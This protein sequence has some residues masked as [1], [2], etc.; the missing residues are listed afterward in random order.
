MASGNKEIFE[1]MNAVTRTVSFKKEGR[2][3]QIRYYC[4]NKEISNELYDK[5]GVLLHRA[6]I[7]PDGV[8]REYYETGA[9]KRAIAFQDGRAHGK[10]IDYYPSGDI[11]EENTFGQGLLQGPS[12]MY[13][14]DGML[15]IEADYDEG[16]LHGLFTSY[17][18]NGNTETRAEYK[19]GKLNGYYAKYDRYGGLMEEGT[20]IEGKKQGDYR[21]YHESG[22]PARVERYR[23]GEIVYLEE[24]DE[25]GR[26]ITVTRSR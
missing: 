2:F 20:F 12:K 8:V 6:G 1:R 3:E 5:N 14:R 17:H 15:W 7:I 9:V 23:Q 11:R 26:V 21:S 19:D 22:E 4:S 18:D 25:D 16:K 24:F 13:R 10:G